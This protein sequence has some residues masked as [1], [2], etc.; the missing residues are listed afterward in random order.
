MT[1]LTIIPIHGIPEVRPG[2]DLAQLIV[3]A[4]DLEDG[5]V[6]VVT[7]KVVSKAENM[8]E[9]I[10]PSNPLSHKP[11]V[12]QESVRIVRRR[13]ELI[14]SETKHGFI[15]ANAGIDLSNVERGQAA[16]LPEDSDR[17]ARRIRDGIRGK[18]GIE[19]GIIIS[20][21]FGRPW[22][23]GL[24]DVAIGVGGLRAIVDLRGTPDALGREMMVTEVCVADELASAAELVMGKADNVAAAIVRGVDPEW[25]GDGSVHD[26]VIRDPAED[27]FR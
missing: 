25:L 20:D 2:D 3:D 9:E 18:A 10:D 6:V 12:E 26:E 19:V 4:G 1:T 22:R 5:D 13:G 17:S 14:V 15:C 21:T 16:L 23:R 7:Q 8:L 24:T 11:L 27:L